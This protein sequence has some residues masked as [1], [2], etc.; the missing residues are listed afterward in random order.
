MLLECGEA[1]GDG[2]ETCT[3]DIGGVVACSA[4]VVVPAF[5]YAVVD[6]ETE[7][8]G[9]CIE[10]EHTFY[11]VVDSEFQIDEILHLLLPCIV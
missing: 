1:V 9:W 11:V 8:S 10:R 4:A 3:L 5:V 2:A 6:V 7:E